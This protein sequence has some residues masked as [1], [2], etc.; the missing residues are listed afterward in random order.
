VNLKTMTIIKKIGIKNTIAMKLVSI[1]AILL[2]KLYIN[3]HFLIQ[4]LAC[5]YMAKI[6]YIFVNDFNYI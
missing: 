5:F 2:K 4:M 6:W 3:L 1:S